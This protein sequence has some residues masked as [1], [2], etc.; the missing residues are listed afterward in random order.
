MHFG[1]N[2]ELITHSLK[3]VLFQIARSLYAQDQANVMDALPQ[4]L[5]PPEHHAQQSLLTSRK[6]FEL[7]LDCRSCDKR[8]FTSG[9]ERTW[10]LLVDMVVQ[11]R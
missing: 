9:C 1:A 7:V 5:E 3:G 2:R 6:S 4:T 10:H 11:C 8:A